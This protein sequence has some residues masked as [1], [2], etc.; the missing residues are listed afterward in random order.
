VF[1]VM[2]VARVVVP[3]VVPTALMHENNA[4]ATAA[5]VRAK[6]RVN[7]FIPLPSFSGSLPKRKRGSSNKVRRPRRQK[8][9]HWVRGFQ[10]PFSESASGGQ[11]DHRRTYVRHAR[12]G[13]R[14]YLLNAAFKLEFHVRPPHRPA[15]QRRLPV[16]AS[17]GQ[18]E[19]PIAR[20]T[21]F[22]S[23]DWL[24]RGWRR[25]ARAWH[26]SFLNVRLQLGVH[27]ISPRKDR[28]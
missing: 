14:T 10:N 7:C 22:F 20:A 9:P 3:K 27:R 15:M 2:A 23:F 11:P 4:I 6:L 24:S 26:G 18:L 25:V 1:V 17:C 13:Y 8:A 19:V 12:G 28:R 21:N 5:T 16:S